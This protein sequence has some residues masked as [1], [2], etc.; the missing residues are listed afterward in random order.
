MNES[1]VERE[2]PEDTGASL[3]DRIAWAYRQIEPV[4]SGGQDFSGQS[5][6]NY[7]LLEQVGRGGMGDVY[8]A[9]RADG[10]FE[11]QVAIKL[12]RASIDSE[13]QTLRFAR[14]RRLLARLEHPGIA[15]LIDG[16]SGPQG[17]PYLVME[18]VDGEPVT[19]HAQRLDLSIEQRLQ[20][21]AEVCRAVAFAHRILIV[22]RDLKP[23]NVLVT[24]DGKVKL[25]DFGIGKLLSEA[26]EDAQPLTRTGAV[27]MTLAYAAPEQILDQPVTTATDVF[28]LGVVLYELLT[29]QRP[30]RRDGLGPV[31]LATQIDT[32][33][34]TRPSDLLRRQAG[35]LVSR[36]L[37]KRLQGDL[38]TIVLTA[39]KHEP[40]RRYAS[41]EV[42]LEDLRRHLDGLPIR[43]RS[44]T[45]AY[46][47]GKFVR[48]HRVGVVAAGL[49]V[50][51][52]IGGLAATLW[53]AQQARSQAQVA[54]R[55]SQRAQ[56]TVEFL[57][58][59]L[60]Q[61]DPDRAQ[62]VAVTV[63]QVLDQ[64]ARSIDIE[65]SAQ[66]HLQAT[67][68]ALIGRIY[69]QLELFEQAEEQLLGAMSNLARLDADGAEIAATEAR[70]AQVYL[71]L[72]RWDEAERLARNSLDRRIARLGEHHP[73]VADSLIALATV[74]YQRGQPER[75]REL[76]G[77]AL[78]LLQ[79]AGPEALGHALNIAARIE[80]D[81]GDFA[82][83]ERR[84]RRAV[85][86]WRTVDPARTRGLAQALA[87][88]SAALTHL[89]QP[90]QLREAEAGWVEAIE[91]ERV[92][93]GDQHRRPAVLLGNLA[94]ARA[95]L[96]DF[97]GG[98]QAL[99]EAL[100]LTVN[101]LGDEH[102]VVST[103]LNNIAVFFHRQGKW[104]EAIDYY[105][106]SIAVSERIHGDGHPEIGATRAFLGLALHRAG[107]ERAESVYRTAL[108]ELIDSRT[109]EH[110]KIGNLRT[111]LGLLLAESGRYAEAERE[112][113]AGLAIVEPIFGTE[114]QRFDSARA[115]L[116]F[117]RCAQ[118]Y[119][120]EGEPLLQA[121]RVWRE[122]RYPE[123]NW[124]RIELDLYDIECQRA[125][126]Q[127]EQARTALTRSLQ[128]L[129]EATPQNQVLVNLAHRL[130]T[131]F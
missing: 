47:L 128:Q 119:A 72:G 22:H 130:Q 99:V 62:G 129:G 34:I 45:A 50:L 65:L 17:I 118:G 32:E 104:P 89:G 48:R 26:E 71:G 93:L 97:D 101:A 81:A 21:F 98:E 19:A 77:R 117:V 15:R 56:Q 12:L 44:D 43:A 60:E 27:P 107:D 59:L 108:R 70:L 54:E 84:G 112:L 25:L 125:R 57:A 38:D 4:T 124:R 90:D 106:R 109:T 51:S 64:A 126:G 13:L 24:R 92:L 122:Q 114:D 30:Y 41:A 35:G 110:E 49:I 11:S 83:A 58:S 6:G 40:E 120:D 102:P 42:L 95:R 23:S 1:E 14:E 86:V 103:Q 82:R 7:R 73:Q 31:A 78:D 39:L 67:M 10:T 74:E 36:R 9:E 37:V 18:W 80:L 76:I 91:I 127:V 100:E 66:P 2:K 33:I 116:G 85:E 79:D 96:G 105:R 61:A 52:L 20:L 63:R 29:G 28:A 3:L 121:A 131:R 55:E 111:D 68:Q 88:H 8:R 53:Q 94:S 5:F 115:G 87:A 75:G 69:G 123:G 46:R 113:R 16:G